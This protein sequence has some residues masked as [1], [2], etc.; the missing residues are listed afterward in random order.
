L[1]INLN[2]Q[3]T[4]STFAIRT[5]QPHRAKIAKEFALSHAKK[6]LILHQKNKKGYDKDEN[7]TAK[8]RR[9]VNI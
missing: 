5:S 4:A 3:R 8:N 1:I 2:S 6:R 7:L 9:A